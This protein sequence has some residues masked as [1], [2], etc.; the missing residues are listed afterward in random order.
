MSRWCLALVSLLA[1]CAHL[2]PGAEKVIVSADPTTIAGCNAVGSV[3]AQTTFLNA[4]FGDW[5]AQGYY[6]IRNQALALHADHIL[7]TSYSQTG[8]AYRC[9]K[10]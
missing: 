7:L 4:L 10:D 1:A 9:E 3:A 5:N 6:A 2:A 8:V